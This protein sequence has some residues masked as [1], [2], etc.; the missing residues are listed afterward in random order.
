MHLT[1]RRGG[2]PLPEF[3]QSWEGYRE[4]D[5]RRRSRCKRCLKTMRKK[6]ENLELG[7]YRETSSM[8]VFTPS[9]SSPAGASAAKRVP[10]EDTIEDRFKSF[11]SSHYGE[12]GI[13]FQL[14]IQLSR[15]CKKPVLQRLLC[16]LQKKAAFRGAFA[17]VA[18]FCY[19]MLTQCLHCLSVVYFGYIW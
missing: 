18:L 9:N 14:A 4:A 8:T 12:Q 2:L 3:R 11:K 7:V 10:V 13:C 19:K 6:K 1:S 16:A 17:C 5:E 15:L